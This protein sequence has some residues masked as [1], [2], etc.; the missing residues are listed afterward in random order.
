MQTH[1][2]TMTERNL[3]QIYQNFEHLVTLKTL[4]RIKSLTNVVPQRVPVDRTPM[5]LELSL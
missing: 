1:K 3:K 5:A 4:N 2:I